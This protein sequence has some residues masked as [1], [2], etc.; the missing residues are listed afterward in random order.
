MTTYMS[1]VPFDPWTRLRLIVSAD[2][3]EALAEFSQS[4]G[5]TEQDTRDTPEFCNL[6]ARLDF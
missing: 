6:A 2:L 4:V 3:G 5:Y 1:L